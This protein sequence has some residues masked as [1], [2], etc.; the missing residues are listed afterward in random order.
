MAHHTQHRNV[1][2]LKDS[3]YVG[4]RQAIYKSHMLTVSKDGRQ[5][6]NVVRQPI[7]QPGVSCILSKK[8][9]PLACLGDTRHTHSL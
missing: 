9:K 4:K 8:V 7:T 2:S 1:S 3:R 6:S 5:G